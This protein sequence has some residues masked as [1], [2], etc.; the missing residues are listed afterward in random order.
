MIEIDIDEHLEN[1]AHALNATGEKVSGKSLARI[2]R[3][4]LREGREAYLD[5]LANDLSEY[6]IPKTRLRRTIHTAFVNAGSDGRSALFNA[7]W[8]R[9]G[10]QRGLQ[11]TS[12]GVV[13]PG[14]GLH[15]GTFLAKTKSGHRGVFRRISGEYMDSNPSK[16]KIRELWGM[17]PNREV[18]R[19]N[20]EA[21]ELAADAAARAIEDQA[22]KLLASIAA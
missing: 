5:E 20:S 13:A 4:A 14:W 16:E 6:K 21:L 15:R 17:N 19:G 2:T 22:H 3:F 18:E 12:L 9:L 10:D 8:F 11:Q 1:F 7:G